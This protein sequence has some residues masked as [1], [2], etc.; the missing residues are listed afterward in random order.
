MA[1][2]TATCPANQAIVGLSGMGT[3]T[4][5]RRLTPIC[6]PVLV[7][8][9]STSGYVL[10]YGATTPATTLGT[11]TAAT[12]GPYEC[13]DGTIGSGFRVN[14]GEILDGISLRCTTQ[15]LTP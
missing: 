14:S 6:A 7:T 13:P 5:V 9:D 1:A 2:V 4:D 3:N 12:F 8:G 11:S 15:R 10:G